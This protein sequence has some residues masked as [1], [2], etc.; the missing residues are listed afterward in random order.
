MSQHNQDRAKKNLHPGS[1]THDAKA[2]GG[3]GDF[4][5]PENDPI[6]R[7]YTS[8]NTKRADPGTAPARSGEDTE[9]VSGVGG[10][11]SGVG[12]SSGGDIDTDIIGLPNRH[13]VESQNQSEKQS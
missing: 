4:G 8:T 11:E 7:N 2:L 5:V 1:S 10:N 9:R 13:E 12:S 3:K 6:E